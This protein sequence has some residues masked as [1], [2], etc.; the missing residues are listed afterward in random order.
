MS[1]L[2]SPMLAQLQSL[3]SVTAERQGL[4]ASNMA[5]IDTPGYQTR[6]LDFGQAMADALQGQDPAEAVETVPGL[7]QRPDG[8]NVSLDRES[9]LMAQTQLQFSTGAALLREEFNR[10]QMAINGGSGSGS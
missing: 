6:D 2:D 3:L 9:V 8:N 4:I 10:I 5:N 1:F 7:V